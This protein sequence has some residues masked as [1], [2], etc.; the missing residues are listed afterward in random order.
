MPPN[1]LAAALHKAGTKTCATSVA[2]APNKGVRSAPL[3]ERFFNG[4]FDFFELIAIR[5]LRTVSDTIVLYRQITKCF[6][7]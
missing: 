5:V 6:H 2:A 3:M 7:R 1:K 4:Y